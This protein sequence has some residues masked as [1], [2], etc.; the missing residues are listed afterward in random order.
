MRKKN[1]K[2]AHICIQPS[3]TYR[4]SHFLLA[5]LDRRSD[6]NDRGDAANRCTGRE[7]KPQVARE[8]KLGRQVGHE[9]HS[10]RDTRGNDRS[11][12]QPQGQNIHRAELE[13]NQYDSR[14]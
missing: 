7:Q 1:S 11:A 9:K 2:P 12:T 5:G 4:N 13:T 10:R 8:P 14:P 3:L 6:R